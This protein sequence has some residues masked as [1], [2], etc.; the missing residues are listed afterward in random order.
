M[1]FSDNNSNTLTHA[2]N[3]KPV[4]CFAIMI[5]MYTVFI[6]LP[7]CW[8]FSEGPKGTLIL[9]E[10]VLLPLEMVLSP[11]LGLSDELACS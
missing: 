3:K 1:F 4:M 6:L 5:L 8:D 7:Y 2:V 11:E 10:I 9:L